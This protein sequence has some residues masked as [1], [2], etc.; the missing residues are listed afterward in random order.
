MA[1]RWV[2]LGWVVLAGLLLQAV[3][4]SGVY[5]AL[6]VGGPAGLVALLAGT[7]PVLVAVGG[8]LFFDERLGGGGVRRRPSFSLRSRYVQK[9][10]DS[11]QLR[12]TGQ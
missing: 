4:F 7:S 9:H 6:Q 8:S 11:L 2:E 5:T 1:R 10:Q 12:S 3:Q